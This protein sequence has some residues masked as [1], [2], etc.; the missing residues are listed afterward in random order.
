M[1]EKGNLVEKSLFSFILSVVATGL[2]GD[3]S[4][5]YSQGPNLV[6]SRWDIGG[7][8]Q[9]TYCS[10]AD[11]IVMFETYGIGQTQSSLE[12]FILLKQCPSLQQGIWI[13]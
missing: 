13:S 3:A 9:C 8:P 1:T 2:W 12:L 4:P 11:I 7:V 5:H 6:R 10:Y